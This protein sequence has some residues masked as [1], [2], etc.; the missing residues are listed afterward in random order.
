MVS[1]VVCH[2]CASCCYQRANQTSSSRLPRST[3][4][5]P[6]AAGPRTWSSRRAAARPWSASR[7][8][9]RPTLVL[10]PN[11]AIQAQW[12]AQWGGAFTSAATIA[13]TA[14][15]DLPT[16][17]TVLTYQAVCTLGNGS[18]TAAR[19]L[20]DERLLETLHPNGQVLLSELS[21]RGPW[22]LV[23]DECHH[24]LEI[25]AACLP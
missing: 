6:L 1:T 10:C 23:L 20:P 24:L 18:A 19:K 22:T 12:I 8:L 3:G 7:R 25:W 15:R 21:A 17:L 16:P 13:A 5:A 2:D 4:P 11:T 9:A 14:D